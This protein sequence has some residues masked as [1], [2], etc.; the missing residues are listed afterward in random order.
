MRI[1]AAAEECVVIHVADQPSETALNTIQWLTAAITNEL[2][3]WVTDIVPSFTTLTVYYDVLT[4]D[5]YRLRDHLLTIISRYPDQNPIS[6]C[7]HIELPVYY[8]PEVALDLVSV[9]AQT[10]LTSEQVITLHGGQSYRVYALGFRPGFAFMGTVVD[11]LRVPRMATPRQK[12][13]RGAVAIT[14]GQ[15]AVYPSVSPGGWNVIG[16]CPLAMFD[17]GDADSEP[18]T[19]LQAGDCVSFKAIS[20]DEFIALGGDLS[21]L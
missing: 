14:E 7:R 4:G 6:Q 5:Y 8:G 19:L 3:H 2:G 18:K 1:V 21:A 10:N 13:P 9:A 17:R 11:Q 12:V 16:N 20:R 15:T